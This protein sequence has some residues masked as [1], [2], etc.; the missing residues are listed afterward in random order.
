MGFGQRVGWSVRQ[1]SMEFARYFSASLIALVLD[2]A[3]LQISARVLH[4]LVAASLGFVVGAISSYV[5]A[6]R[7]V[8]RRRRLGEH[9]PMEFSAF[10]SIG[11]VGLGISDLVIFLAVDQWGL[12]LIGG[13]LIAAGITFFLNYAIK[14]RALF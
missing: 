5:L 8:F 12:S 3:V 6:T 1:P 2:V 11:L 4:Y 9:A 13:K 14:K 7:W 10:V